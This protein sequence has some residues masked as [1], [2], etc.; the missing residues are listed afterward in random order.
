MDEVEPYL[1]KVSVD[2]KY[3]QTKAQ[4]T[5]TSEEDDKYLHTHPPHPKLS[6]DQSAMENWQTHG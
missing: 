1:S 3:K 4:I 6:P 2:A 5:Y